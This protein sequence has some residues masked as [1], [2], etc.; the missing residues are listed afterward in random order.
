MVEL[1]R[2][3]SPPKAQELPASGNRTKLCILLLG[4]ELRSE[5]SIAFL[6]RSDDYDIRIAQSGSE[7]VEMGLRHPPDVV[8]LAI[9]RADMDGWQVAKGLQAPATRKQPFLIALS[10]CGGEDDRRRSEEAGIHLHLEK[11]FDPKLLQKLLHRFHSLLVD[12]E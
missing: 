9:D 4:I 11:T 2:L 1:T 6:F 3:R 8:L 10:A 5:T 7:A 12:A